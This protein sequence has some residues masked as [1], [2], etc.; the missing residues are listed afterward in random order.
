MDSF[1]TFADKKINSMINYNFKRVWKLADES[2]A[3]AY[4]E[5][6]RL[7]N[8]IRKAIGLPEYDMDTFDEG[9]MHRVIFA[10]DYKAAKDEFANLVV[11]WW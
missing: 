10:D 4:K 1:K 8:R 2:L 6:Y 7:C 9:Y 11:G 3:D 5:S